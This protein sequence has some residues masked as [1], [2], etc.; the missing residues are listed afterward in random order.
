MTSRRDSAALDRLGSEAA[1]AHPARVAR[2]RA[3]LEV[4]AEKAAADAEAVAQAGDQSG[5]DAARSIAAAITRM[6]R[7]LATP[8]DRD[9]A[10]T[11]AAGG[12]SVRTEQ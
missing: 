1:R 2:V 9:A 11:P 6:H 8:E 5:A 10:A 4:E 12:D 7:A 3:D